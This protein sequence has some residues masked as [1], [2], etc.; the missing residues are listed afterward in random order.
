MANYEEP[1]L[2]VEQR[3]RRNR[4]RPTRRNRTKEELDNG[5]GSRS[6]IHGGQSS[7]GEDTSATANAA[8]PA[9]AVNPPVEDNFADLVSVASETIGARNL[10]H[11][12]RQ[13][14]IQELPN[15][16]IASAS[17]PVRY[18]FQVALLLALLAV[19]QVSPAS[20]NSAAPEHLTVFEHVG[21]MIP[22]VS[23]LHVVVPVDLERYE[24]MFTGA[25]DLISENK[26]SFKNTKEYKDEEYYHPKTDGNHDIYIA[27]HYTH[28]PGAKSNISMEHD[29]SELY[30]RFRSIKD[31]MPAMSSSLRSEAIQHIMGPGGTGHFLQGMTFRSQYNSTSGFSR[32]QRRQDEEEA[33]PDEL[34]FRPRSKRFWGYIGAAIAGGVMGTFLGVYT[35]QQVQSM[36]TAHDTDLLV[37][38][39][40]A[41]NRIIRTLNERINTAITFSME[42]AEGQFF[43]NRYMVW[44]SVVRHLKNQLDDF[45]HLIDSLQKHRLSHTWFN[46]EQMAQLHQNVNLFG[47]KHAVLPLTDYASDY[48]QVDVSYVST[49]TQLIILLHVPAT[50]VKEKW[51]IFRYHPFP[52]PD[53]KKMVTM[54]TAPEPLIAMG[55]DRRYKVLTESDLHHCLRRNHNYL[56]NSP[57]ITHTNF[58][59][60]CIGAIMGQLPDKISSLCRIHIEPERE[61]VMQASERTFAVYSPVAF[62]AHGTCINGTI[63][64]KPIGLSNQIEVGPGCNLQLKDHII[65]VPFSLTAPRMPMIT[66][67]NWDTMEVPKQLLREDDLRQMKLYKLLTNDSRNEEAVQEGLRVS[68]AQ[69]A[70]LHDRLTQEVAQQSQTGLIIFACLGGIVTAIL[71]ILLVCWCARYWCQRGAAR[72]GTAEPAVHYHVDPRRQAAVF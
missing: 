36:A 43:L 26:K 46:N 21:D 14:L 65:E 70:M 56:C 71:C 42:A 33:D 5:R 72:S 39:N 12:T 53:K 37:Q 52:I 28:G 23:Y 67:T 10:H 24:K 35:H 17:S 15:Q 7:H 30:N 40:Q 13:T 48:F 47:R 2:V 45:S 62:T 29:L 58:A 57:V 68:Q 6:S 32:R 20:F 64:T 8:T 4:R 61:M 34:E 3:R 44:A 69:L 22:D 16:I 9:V 59:S 18:R 41:K 25:L 63:T 49:P 51:N 27:N 50:R 11:S 60:A 38:E 66:P 19:P 55:T 31:N 54:I 1:D